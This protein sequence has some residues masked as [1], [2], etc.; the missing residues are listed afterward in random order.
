MEHLRTPSCAMFSL[1]WLKSSSN[2]TTNDSSSDGTTSSNITDGGGS[3][4]LPVRSL[5]FKK[6]KQ[7]WVSHLE[8]DTHPSGSKCNDAGRTCL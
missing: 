6:K 2:E 3:V 7:F 5:R 4:F 1:R 8:V